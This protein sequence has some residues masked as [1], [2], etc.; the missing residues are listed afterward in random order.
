MV[1][2]GYRAAAR[3]AALGWLVAALPAAAGAEQAPPA[4]AERPV[5]DARGVWAELACPEVGAAL[6]SPL[7]LAEVRGRAGQGPRASFDIVLALDLSESALYPSGSDVD[8]DGVTARVRGNAA[9]GV[10]GAYRPVASWTTDAD[11]T[12][13][14]AEIEA[15]RRLLGQLDADS[16]RVG[17]LSFTGRSRV[18]ADI[19]A[20]ADAR[21]ALDALRPR[22][23]RDGTDLGAA[24]RA[25]VRLLQQAQQP[26]DGLRQQVL[27]VLSDGEATAPSPAIY[28]RRAALRAAERA[29]GAG[30]RIFAFALGDIPEGAA[31]LAELA[32]LTG[33]AFSK[34]ER[35][36]DV[37]DHLPYAHL[38][39]LESVR[40]EN[41]T[42][43][44]VGRA[45]RLFADGSFDGF[46]P[47]VPGANHIEIT[48]RARTGEQVQVRRE[49]TFEPEPASS[50]DFLAELAA[51][52]RLLETRTIE[53][54]LAAQVR[55][56]EL[57]RRLAITVDPWR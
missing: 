24:V 37:L 9:R 57:E 13:L 52:N 35:V 14:R 22:L 28:A 25:G 21:A 11:D 31:L 12:V 23:T 6:S 46:V 26:Q 17:L 8:G 36:G 1:P 34:L 19:G 47:L 40:M 51:L 20:L 56:R 53:S 33:G 54:N 42:A 50:P 18:R 29:R 10:G 30:V 45:V 7:A 5:V 3:L 38:A 49:V 27:I 2:P 44:Q 4:L 43:Q 32:D 41:R 55:Q 16:T 48:V 15:A 39:D